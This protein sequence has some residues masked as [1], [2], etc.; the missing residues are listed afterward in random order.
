VL[1]R[2]GLQLSAVVYL[3]FA[4]SFGAAGI[5]SWS[6]DHAGAAGTSGGMLHHVGHAA[7]LT[8]M[9]PMTEMELGLALVFAYF[10]ISSLARASRR[11]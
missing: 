8:Q 9:A 4:L 5:K 10:G 6:V 7:S 11:P 1:G 3:V 2:L